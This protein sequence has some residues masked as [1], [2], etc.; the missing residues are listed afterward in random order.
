M[1]RKPIIGIRVETGF[2]QVK[3]FIYSGLIEAL[4]RRYTIIWI[5]PRDISEELRI[6][7]ERYG[8]FLFIDFKCSKT[9]LKIQSLHRAIR[10]AWLLKKGEQLFKLYNKPRPKRVRDRFLGINLLRYFADLFIL[11]RI[12]HWYSASDFIDQLRK[13]KIE[14]L[15]TT[16]Y[17]S[18]MSKVFF[19][20]SN[21]LSVPLFLMINSW[22]DIFVNSFIPF[23]Q[24][25]EIWVWDNQMINDILKRNP[26]LKQSKFKI[27]GNSSFDQLINYSPKYNKVYYDNKYGADSNKSWIYWTM[28][29]PGIYDDEIDVLIAVGKKLLEAGLKT[30][31]LVRRN[32]NHGEKDF[33]DR[34]LPDNITFT[35]HLIKYD[36]EKDEIIQ[37][38]EDEIEWYD[39]LYHS[40]L[41]ISIPSTVTLEFIFFNKHVINYE[42]DKQNQINHNLKSFFE[43]G[44]YKP[45]FS[46]SN[47]V[48]RAQ[49]MAE[50]INSVAKHINNDEQAVA[51]HKKSSQIII[52]RL[53]QYLQCL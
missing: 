19:A 35:N 40:K 31:L 13:N 16:S 39:L 47:Y 9:G 11:S 8:T 44:F 45:L 26:H 48:H 23:A 43:S 49:N 28:A 20:A 5:A 32:P 34:E 29:P 15:I 46:N 22:K 21:Q 37:P 18:E 14:A 42:F 52:Q 33:S 12:R 27:T 36:Q 30:H 41:N 3:K 53:D 1:D 7:F 6:I 4:T 2:H 17:N 38:L 25:R 10:E 51:G 50:L 24:I